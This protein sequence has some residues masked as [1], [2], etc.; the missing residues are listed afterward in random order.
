MIFLGDFRDSL[1]ICHFKA[2]VPQ[3]FAVQHSGFISYGF[4][5][6][7]GVTRVDKVNSNAKLGQDIIKL[8]VRTPIQIVC[9]DDLVAM[10]AYIYDGIKNEK[11]KMKKHLIIVLLAI[12]GLCLGSLGMNG[13]ASEEKGPE[14]RK[15]RKPAEDHRINAFMTKKIIGSD[16]FNL[17]NE[18]LG[19]IGDL[20]IDID[21]GRIVY[22]ILDFGSFLGMH[23]KHFPVPWKSLLA[24][25]SEGIFFLNQSKE[26]LEKAPAFDRDKL[27]DMGHMRWGSDIYR[28]YGHDYDHGYDYNYGPGYHNYRYEL[29]PGTWQ[30]DPYQKIFDARTIKTIAGKVIKVESVDE[31]GFGMT[32]RLIVYTDKEILPVYLGPTW[33]IVGAGPE[34]RF[35][36]GDEVTVSGSQVTLDDEPF[37]LAMTVKRGHGVLQ[38]R[39]KDGIPVWNWMGKQE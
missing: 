4:L 29:Y 2:G 9:G 19:K 33:Y 17:K 37:M 13:F 31:P 32:V 14:I 26:Q 5:K 3:S 28:Y 11:Y 20:V 6:V 25:P 38:L 30:N 1:D 7:C 10:L 22:A 12:V 21:T 39:K 16:V 23:E 8:G 27:P 18:K 15:V 24:L 35:K 36:S 34:K